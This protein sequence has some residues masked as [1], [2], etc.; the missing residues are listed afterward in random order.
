MDKRDLTALA[1]NSVFAICEE[2]SPLEAVGTVGVPVKEGDVAKTT[3]PVPVSSVNAVA[4]S[5]EEKEPKEVVFPDV[6]IAPVKCE[7]ELPPP[8]GVQTPEVMFPF[9]APSGFEK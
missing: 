5:V 9:V 7:L 6:T 8:I 1:T 2:L 3:L 4:S